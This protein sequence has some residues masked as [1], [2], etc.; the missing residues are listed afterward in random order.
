MSEVAVTWV[1]GAIVT[2][3]EVAG[4]DDAKSTDG[5]QRAALRSP[6]CVL[7]ITRVVDDFAVTAAGQT[8]ASR[9]NVSRVGA[10]VPR[11]AIA[12]QP[13]HIVAMICAVTCVVPTVVSLAFVIGVGR[14]TRTTPERHLVVI[15]VPIALAWVA[16]VVVVAWIEIHVASA[17]LNAA[18]LTSN[19]GLRR[20]C[21]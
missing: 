18:L 6:K 17:E 5:R 20:M 7:A 10:T 14:R 19:A 15:V 21:A 8:E 2:V 13:A 4:R 9:E 1:R 3:S 12:L 11:L 16:F